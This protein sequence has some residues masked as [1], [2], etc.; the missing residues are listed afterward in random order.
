M[1]LRK[2]VI[3]L[4][5]DK[6]DLRKDLLPLLRKRAFST[7]SIPELQQELQKNWDKFLADMGRSSSEEAAADNPRRDFD[8]FASIYSKYTFFPVI[9]TGFD[10]AEKILAEKSVPK[11]QAKKLEMATR[12]FMSTKA[13]PRKFASWLKKNTKHV[14]FMLKA[15]TWGDKNEAS[16]DSEEKFELA[17]FT[18]INTI[19]A[20]GK[21]LQ[22][23]KD[24]ILKVAR[25]I[26]NSGIT[27]ATQILY[28]NVYLVGQLRK[29]GVLAWYNPE[30]DQVYI[31]P[32]ARMGVDELHQLA[33]ELGH[34]LWDRFLPGDLKQEW[35]THHRAVGGGPTDKVVLEPGV[36]IP[37]VKIK[38]IKGDPTVEKIEDGFVFFEGSTGR[39]PR[40]SVWKALYD[41]NQLLVFPTRYSAKNQ[42]EHF[43]ESF[44]LFVLNQL[45]GAHKEAFGNIFK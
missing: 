10:L 28:G 6:P 30:D 43:C 44:A 37:G 9:N 32:A 40:R 7:K 20:A 12:L 2:A 42:E 41:E 39:Y 14:E 8:W 19:E 45:T 23:T 35:G 4:A 13:S 21:K 11:G 25:S 17:G 38:G 27:K 31:R 22:T 15:A 29:R 24:A 36:S 5:H 1:D 18:V 34:R 33:H 26:R 3:K 16:A